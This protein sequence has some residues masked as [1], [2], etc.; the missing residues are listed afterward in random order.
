MVI[1]VFSTLLVTG[2]M[3]DADNS[4]L[5]PNYQC[6][7]WQPH[8][9][10]KWTPLYDANCKELC[11]QLIDVYISI[12]EVTHIYEKEVNALQ[13][14]IIVQKCSAARLQRSQNSSEVSCAGE[15]WTQGF[16]LESEEGVTGEI[17]LHLRVFLN[18]KKA[19][20]DLTSLLRYDV[21]AHTKGRVG[22]HWFS[23][24]PS[25]HPGNILLR[26]II[27]SLKPGK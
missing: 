6:I 15:C 27:L 22:F 2:L 16:S 23:S 10:N 26:L 21:I 9:Q 17:S 8:Q 3:Q 20:N 19:Q 13:G 1:F 11:V 4:Y 5:D 18:A 24:S 14:G 25:E 7:K 12:L